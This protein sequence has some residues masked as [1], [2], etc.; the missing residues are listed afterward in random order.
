LLVTAGLIAYLLRKVEVGPVV[1]HV[2]AIEAG[3]ALL[4]LL[5]MLLQLALVSLRW[6]LVNRIVGART[7][8]GQALRLTWI[9]QFFNQVLPS[10]VGGDAVR[11]WLASREG[12]PVGRAVTGVVCDRAAALAALIL[13]ISATFLL[14]PTFVPGKIPSIEALR[15]V[16]GAGL[17]GLAALFV[18]GASLAAFLMR[19]RATE[20]I[21]KLVRDLRAVLCLSAASAAITVLSGVVQ[22]LL[23]AVVVLCALGMNIPL[24]FG[25]ALLVVPAIMLISM[26]PISFAGWGVREGAMIVGL[27]ELGVSASDAL[28]IS[29]AFGLLQM[30]AALPGGALWLVGKR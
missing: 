26:I 28:A 15:L 23:V 4:A 9:G 25:G 8:I 5:I 3:P 29:V 18:F 11:V 6:N 27:G 17:L 21:G 16:A 22:L 7:G 10:T 24:A 19:H 2:G 1:R 30:A 14:A 20:S 13:I 12:V